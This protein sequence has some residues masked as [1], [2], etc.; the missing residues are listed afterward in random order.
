MGTS[1][2]LAYSIAELPEAWMHSGSGTLSKALRLV[3]CLKH[4]NY[5][6]IFLEYVRNPWTSAYPSIC[7]LLCP[8]TV[9]LDVLIRNIKKKLP[10]AVHTSVLPAIWKAEVGRLQI[11][12]QL[13]SL[14]SP[15]LKKMVNKL[16]NIKLTVL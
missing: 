2:I 13:G 1:T 11:Q 14:A 9:C 4:S 7:E 6:L 15:S 10:G 12:V 16:N 3:R 8:S 5:L